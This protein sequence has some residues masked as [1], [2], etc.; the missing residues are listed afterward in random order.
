M[1][2]LFWTVSVILQAGSHYYR[3]APNYSIIL[4][5]QFKLLTD[6]PN[7]RNKSFINAWNGLPLEP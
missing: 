2:V 6:P 7:S 4:Q 1:T 3:P 5:Q